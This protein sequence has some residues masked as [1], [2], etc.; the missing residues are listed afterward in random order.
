MVQTGWD[1]DNTPLCQR[2]SDRKEMFRHIFSCMSSNASTTFK[3]A[4][5]VFKNSLRKCNTVPIITMTFEKFLNRVRKGYDVPIP[6]NK[7][8][9]QVMNDLVELTLIHKLEISPAFFLH[10]FVSTNWDL[11]QN[12]YLKKKDFNDRQT[13]WAVKIIKTIWEFSSPMWKARCDLIHS[14]LEKKTKSAR[15]NELIEQ[16]RKELTRT[17]YHADH[18]TQQLRENVEKSMANAQIDVLVVENIR[19]TQ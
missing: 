18:T 17:E 3:K 11:V 9:T 15:R 5:S 19:I 1:G 2:C 13:D 16:I 7:L 4:M 12:M 8:N 10:G 6:Y 14:N